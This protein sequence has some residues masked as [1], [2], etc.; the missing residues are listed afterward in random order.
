MT[1]AKGILAVLLAAVLLMG[2]AAA[3]ST[4]EEIEAR[5]EQACYINPNGGRYVHTVPDC[6]TV[7]PA[8]LPLTRV[9]YTDEIRQWYP[10]CSVCCSEEYLAAREKERQLFEQVIEEY[11][12]AI[13]DPHYDSD[14]T[15]TFTSCE[16]RDYADDP[17]SQPAYALVKA[18]GLTTLL[19]GD[20]GDP[21]GT[22]RR[23]YRK[24]NDEIV[25]V[26]EKAEI[27]GLVLLADGHEITESELAAREDIQPVEW[28]RFLNS[29]KAIVG[30]E[31]KGGLNAR[32]SLGAGGYSLGL[33]ATGEVV[34]VDEVVDGWAWFRYNSTR[35]G[36]SAGSWG[37]VPDSGL[38]Y[39]EKTEPV[40]TAV[41]ARNGK[42]SGTAV[43]NVRFRPTT[44]ARKILELPIGTEVDVYGSENGWTEIEWNRWHGYVKDEFIQQK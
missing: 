15:D 11:R 14:F 23:I 3:E 22:V 17:R 21:A 9:E 30:G 37:Y 38:I 42:T 4:D 19:I 24:V 25:C 27:P 40:G 31:E 35:N 32:N 26:L 1:R 28:T 8:V 2:A 39:P 36:I 12:T 33:E 43:I 16:W 7:F 44:A 5:L 13:R 41:L 29:R 6:E 10:F 20:C 18:N 34:V